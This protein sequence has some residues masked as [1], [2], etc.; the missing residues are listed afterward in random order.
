MGSP[1]TATEEPG[2]PA[3]CVV[4]SGESPPPFPPAF[5][6][7]LPSLFCEVVPALPDCGDGGGVL[8]QHRPLPRQCALLQ[9]GM[10]GAL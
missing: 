8:H 4:G 9:G 7:V 3:T 10:A 5:D 6:E 2:S 1:A